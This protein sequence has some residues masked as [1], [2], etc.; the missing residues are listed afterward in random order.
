MA[1]LSSTGIWSM[2]QAGEL[3]PEDANALL[4]L[5][6]LKGSFSYAESKNTN[7]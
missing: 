6:G 7:G 1:M 2:L 5:A 4:E 3:K